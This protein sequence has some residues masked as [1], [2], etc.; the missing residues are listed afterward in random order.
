MA[1]N[2]IGGDFFFET[3]VDAN[4]QTCKERDVKGLYKL[5]EQGKIKNFTGVNSPYERPVL[6]AIHLHSDT[7][8]LNN[9]INQILKYLTAHKI[10]NLQPALQLE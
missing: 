10:I 2:I 7:E 3:F 8:S 4:I 5:A 1:K 6:P 9:C